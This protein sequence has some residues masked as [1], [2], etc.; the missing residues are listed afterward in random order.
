MKRLQAS[1]LTIP[2][3]DPVAGKPQILDAVHPRAS[4]V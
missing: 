3:G 4:R 1:K 2:K